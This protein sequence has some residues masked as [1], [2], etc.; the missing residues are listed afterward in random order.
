MSDRART[1]RTGSLRRMAAAVVAATVGIV[2]AASCTGAEG[3][4]SEVSAAVDDLGSDAGS[5]ARLV[6]LVSEDGLGAD[7][8]AI[9]ADRLHDHLDELAAAARGESAISRPEAVALF[10]ALL[11]HGGSDV[12]IDSLTDWT[13]DA[14]QPLIGTDP[15]RSELDRV[16][17][18]VAAVLEAAAEGAE[19]ADDDTTTLRGAVTQGARDQ[20]AHLV[21]DAA[22]RPPPQPGEYADLLAAHF[23]TDPMGVLNGHARRHLD[24]GPQDPFAEWPR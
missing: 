21:A 12:V 6:A 7:D 16:L 1:A 9:V 24:V 11:D 3:G 5:F 20:V 19:V 10:A 2:A 23:G 15:T 13:V 17:R 18:P 8:A 4:S 22:G 14:V